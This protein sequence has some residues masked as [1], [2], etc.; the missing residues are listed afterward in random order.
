M[1]PADIATI[2]FPARLDPPRLP[3]AGMSL[4]H[5]T[6]EDFP[7]LL[8]LYRSFRA[9]ELAAVPWS[10][11]QKHAFLQQQFLF[12]HRHYMATFPDTDFLVV[13]IGGEP[14]GRVYLDAKKERWLIVDIGVLPQWRRQGH[15]TTLLAAIQH[16][17]TVSDC[18]AVV[19]HVE[20]HN[21]RAQAL[22]HRLGF[23]AEENGGSHVQMEWSCCNLAETGRL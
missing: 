14:A 21:F 16:E 5:A 22:Y 1:L 15:G 8:Q 2:G 11:E 7:F 13:E 19:L 6:S 12:Q 3:V 4:R 23:R 9:E 17:A 20:Q 18:E 10:I